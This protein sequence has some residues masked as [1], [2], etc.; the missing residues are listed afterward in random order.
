MLPRMTRR[1]APLAALL[2]LA[3]PAAA[4]DVRYKA[5]VAGIPVGEGRLTGEVGRTAY[6]VTLA[7]TSGIAAWTTRF[8]T[9]A[10]GAIAGGRVVPS[11]YV[12]TSQGRTSRTTSVAFAGGEARATIEPPPDP[13]MN[14]GR[15]PLTDAHRRGVVDPLSGLVAQALAGAFEADPCRGLTRGFSGW[16]GSTWPCARAAPRRTAR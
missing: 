9:R 5:T 8:T 13:E 2:V 1:L 4:L 12:S 14:A 15:V 7:G 11:R 10:S 3:S 6:D 16:R